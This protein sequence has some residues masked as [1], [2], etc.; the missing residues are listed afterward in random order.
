MDVKN[1]INQIK[2]LVRKGNVSKIV[3]RRKGVLPPP[4]GRFWPR[5]WARWASAAPWRS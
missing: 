5:C 1:V 4:S 2:E 3:V